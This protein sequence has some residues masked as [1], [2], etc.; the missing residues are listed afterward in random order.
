MTR[1]ATAFLG[2]A[3]RLGAAFRLGAALRFAG[4]LRFGAAFLTAFFLP[5]VAEMV[6]VG[7]MDVAANLRYWVACRKRTP[8]PVI[9]RRNC[10]DA[11]AHA[12]SGAP[13]VMVASD[14]AAASCAAG[15][16]R[17]KGLAASSLGT[18]CR[19]GAET[20]AG[21]GPTKACAPLKHRAAMLTRIMV[22]TK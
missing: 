16:T 6:V 18:A 19:A 21:C 1:R 11:A 4:A 2:A 7:A 3:L 20:R 13:I 14:S 10:L 8:A 5:L 9:F 12:T 17:A 15:W 22:F